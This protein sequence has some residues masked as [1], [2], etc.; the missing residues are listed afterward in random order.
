VIDATLQSDAS[1]EE[2]AELQA[3]VDSIEIELLGGP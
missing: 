2:L 3:I 1:P